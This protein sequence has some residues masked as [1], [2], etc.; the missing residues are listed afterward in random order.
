[1]SLQF[2]FNL[3]VTKLWVVQMKSLQGQYQTLI[4][5]FTLAQHFASMSLPAF[6]IQAPQPLEG[7]FYPPVLCTG[8]GKLRH[9]KG[10]ANAPK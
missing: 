4:A 6:G 10:K 1:M 3:R 7:M 8:G 9:S 5:H 2:C